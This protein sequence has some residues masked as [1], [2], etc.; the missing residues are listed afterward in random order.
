ML[1]S[2]YYSKIDMRKYGG[3]VNNFWAKVEKTETCWLW[4]GAKSDFG[5]GRFRISRKKE[6]RAHRFSWM[7]HNGEIPL[8]LVV[9][10]KCD[11]PACVNPDHLFLG[12]MRD[13]TA[14]S[15]LTPENVEKILVDNRTGRVIAEE[16]GICQ[17]SVSLIKRRINWR[18]I[19]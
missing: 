2:A 9:C 7:L 14:G 17:Q 15:K 18:I 3:N 11:I 1:G 19:E 4:L 6:H 5:H 13:N 10:H 16:Y 12:T 8:G